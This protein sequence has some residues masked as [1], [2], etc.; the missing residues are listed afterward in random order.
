M[1]AVLTH[2]IFLF[3]GLKT[4]LKGRHLNRTEFIEAESLAVLNTLAKYDFQGEFK[5][6]RSACNGAYARKGT[7][8]RVV[9]ARKPPKLVFDQM[10][11]TTPGIMDNSLYT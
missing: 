4:K 8:L 2:P 10:A 9:A 6:G 5:N 11:A 3:P 1:T 7:S